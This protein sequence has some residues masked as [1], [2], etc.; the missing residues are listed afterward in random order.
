VQ[1]P[2]R[3]VQTPVRE[4]QT[5]VRSVQTPARSV[6][7]PSQGCANH[8]VRDFGW[9]IAHGA[10]S[11]RPADSRDT[12]VARTHL[13]TY[14]PN[15]WDSSLVQGPFSVAPC[16]TVAS[17]FATLASQALV[18]LNSPEAVLGNR[19]IQLQWAR[20][21]VLQGIDALINMKKSL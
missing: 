12:S 6:A 17:R 16:Q 10:V 11:R 7:N 19:F 5:P 8:H 18:A 21:D 9:E 14:A 4:V 13:Y 3:S 1:T 15:V 20:Y 2:A